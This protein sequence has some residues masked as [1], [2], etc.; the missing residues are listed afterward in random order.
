MSRVSVGVALGL[1]LFVVVCFT[2]QSGEGQED[3]AE[4]KAYAAAAA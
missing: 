2:G 3:L 4:L 1:T